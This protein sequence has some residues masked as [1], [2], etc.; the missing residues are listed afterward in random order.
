MHTDDNSSKTK[1]HSKLFLLYMKDFA[2]K[3]LGLFLFT[4]V[5]ISCDEIPDGIVDVKTVNY[6]VMGIT[7]PSTFIYSPADSTIV[8]SVQIQ[9]VETVSN[10]WCK[11]SSF[12]GTLTINNQIF[13]FD[14]GNVSLHGDQNK[15]DGIYSGKV[16]M[17]KSNPNGKYQVEF[18]I[19]DNVRISPDNVQ[20]VGAQIFSYNNN[21][22]NLPPVISNLNIPSSVNREVN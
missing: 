12:D 20:K 6:N 7:A 3:I 13:M 21:Q 1:I 18:F 22:Q 15:G 14:D 19:E 17:S 5:F 10:V 11:V 9:N 8:T 16:N 4:V 2:I